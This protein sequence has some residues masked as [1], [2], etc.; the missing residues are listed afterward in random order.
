M[1]LKDRYL[2]V[3]GWKRECGETDPGPVVLYDPVMAIERWN[4]S[5]P[6]ERRPLGGLFLCLM[7]TRVE[8]D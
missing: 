3:S 4:T 2:R 5:A 1:D 7:S 6:I 8:G